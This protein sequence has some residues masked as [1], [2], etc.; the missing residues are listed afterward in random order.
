MRRRRSGNDGLLRGNYT[1]QLREISSDQDPHFDSKIFIIP[2][3]KASKDRLTDLPVFVPASELDKAKQETAAAKAAQTSVH[4]I[5]KTA[6]L[7]SSHLFVVRGRLLPAAAS[8][9]SSPGA[10]LARRCKARR[11]M[12]VMGP[13][14]H[15]TQF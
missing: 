4:L 11:S 6:A 8:N 3:D 7:I 5:E 10:I 2:G 13:H 15:I 1:L 12:K 9:A 14:I